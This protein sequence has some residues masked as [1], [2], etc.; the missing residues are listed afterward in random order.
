MTEAPAML[1]FGARL[2]DFMILQTGI[3]S[4]LAVAVFLVFALWNALRSAH[5]TEA[6]GGRRRRRW[7]FLSS[8]SDYYILSLLFF[9]LILAIGQILSARW[10]NLGYVV[11]GAYCM[12]QGILQQTGDV[13][14]SLS[15]LA[16]AV[17]TFAVLFFRWQPPKSKWLPLSVIAGIC[18]FLLLAT[19]IPALT[20]PGFWDI[21][22]DWCWI[23]PSYRSLQ[24]GLEY[25]IFWIVALTSFALY[26]P[27]FFCLRGNLLVDFSTEDWS[28]GKMRVSWRWIKS[29]EAWKGNDNGAGGAP[30]KAEV[31]N[32]M[33]MARRML[34]YPIVYTLMILPS[35]VFRGLELTHGNNL[36]IPSAAL[37]F[38]GIVYTMSGLVNVTLYLITRPAVFD[39]LGSVL[40]NRQVNRADDHDDREAQA[41]RDSDD[42]TPPESSRPSYE[43]AAIK[44]AEASEGVQYG[45]NMDPCRDIETE[46]GVEPGRIR[47]RTQTE[48]S[49]AEGKGEGPS[50]PGYAVP[51]MPVN[52]AVSENVPSEYSLSWSSVH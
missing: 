15:S 23:S 26:I 2:G 50:S 41:A 7:R 48:A 47:Q 39:F 27:L 32:Q 30:V 45:T 43:K 25:C 24:V 19:L 33:A 28:R 49:H 44:K 6:Q 38:S 3:C 10:I 29:D 11:P 20:R 52:D 42:E 9:D 1:S 34:A 4:F 16:I 12:A 13:G 36:T 5:A 21:S 8:T 40:C 37:A 17:H 31:K 18:L 35:S 14:V 22:G 51:T 46:E